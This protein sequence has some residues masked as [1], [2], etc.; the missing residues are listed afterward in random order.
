M[1]KVVLFSMLALL[2]LTV[3]TVGTIAQ[4]KDFKYVGV[5]NCKMCHSSKKSGE[6]YKIWEASAHAKAYLTLASEESKAIA[7]KMSIDDPQKSDQCLSC[8][9]TGHGQAASKFEKTY[10]QEEG[11]S[12]EACHG[13][14][15]AYNTMKIMKQITAGD[16]KG[17]DY[18]LLQPN[19]ANCKTCHNEKSPTFKG[20]DFNEYVAMIAHPT[21]KE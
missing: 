9:T 19:E 14:G 3:F 5:K 10:T 6:A 13:A 7:K 21:P 15:S 2:V 18:G 8:H 16:V 20:F 12:C 11:V 17:A 4:D 1:V